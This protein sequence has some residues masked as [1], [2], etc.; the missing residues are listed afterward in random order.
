MLAAAMLTT[1]Q[2]HVVAV[3]TL[4]HL[5]QTCALNSVL[6]FPLAQFF[7]QMM[8]GVEDKGKYNQEEF[9]NFMKNAQM[10]IIDSS[11]CVLD[12]ETTFPFMAS[13]ERHVE[14]TTD[15]KTSSKIQRRELMIH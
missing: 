15:G 5:M 3:T 8:S 7:G 4:T 6:K 1:L 13:Y 14:M 2:S 11:V 10:S 12:P 9:E